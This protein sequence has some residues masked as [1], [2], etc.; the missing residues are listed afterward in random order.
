MK[1]K[2]D[3]MLQQIAENN[4]ASTV[5]FVTGSTS[6][7]PTG[8]MARDTGVPMY[9]ETGSGF[10]VEPDKIVTTIE[11]LAGTFGVAAIRADRLAKFASKG[12]RLFRKRN[13]FQMSDEEKLGVSIEGV[14][15][16]DAKNNLVLLKVAE[17]RAPLPIGNS[18]TFEIGEKVYTLGYPDDMKYMCVAGSLQSRYKDNKWFQ[19]RTLFLSGNGGGPVLNSQNEV[20]GVVA[21]GTGSVIGDNNKATI[22]TAK[23]SKVLKELLEKAG[24]VM[25]LE[26]WQKH[27]RVRAYALEAQAD[28]KA[29]RYD[30]REAIRDYNAA[31]KSNP[32]L[33]EIYSKR[34]IVKGRIENFQGAFKDFDRMIRIN[35][36]HIFAYNN[37]AS[38]K[39]NLGDEQSALDDLNK[40][41][42]LN[43]EYIMAYVNLG[44]VKRLIAETKTDEGDIVEAQRY[45]QEAIDDYTKA[46]ALN[47]RNSLA[48]K[49]RRDTKR[50][51][52]LLRSQQE[53]E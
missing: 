34:G 51:L 21:Y 38:A 47:P 36:E 10:F 40:A 43:P 45:Y 5:L 27:A 23:S 50:I 31:L 2:K 16:F 7:Q 4:R 29:E 37:R 42:A 46:L 48:R 30:N 32:D 39:A 52:Q 44:G 9:I 8:L 41:I 1:K 22:A 26:Q 17:T 28:E 53:T 19:L 14:T 15:A 24:K 20:V 6:E 11:I 49:N 12:T 18:D 33:V 3:A 13:D 25:S 35:P